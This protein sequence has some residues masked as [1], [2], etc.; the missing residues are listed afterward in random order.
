[1]RDLRHNEVNGDVKGAH[2]NTRIIWADIGGH[3]NVLH[4]MVSTALDTVRNFETFHIASCFEEHAISIS[5]RHE[6]LPS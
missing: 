2:G 1:M 3:M 6:W 4:A 5:L